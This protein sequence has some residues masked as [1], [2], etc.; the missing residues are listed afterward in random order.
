MTTSFGELLQESLTPTWTMAYDV[1]QRVSGIKERG[2]A[3]Y[4]QGD[5]AGAYVTFGEALKL[6][7]LDQ[8]AVQMVHTSAT[9]DRYVLNSVLSLL[10]SLFS[11]LAITTYKLGYWEVVLHYAS[12]AVVLIEKFSNAGERDKPLLWRARAFDQL[13]L[14]LHALSDAFS[15]R[16][17][18]PE[19]KELI[20][21]LQP[22]Y[23]ALTSGHRRALPLTASLRV[24]S[25]NAFADHGVQLAPGA[26]AAAGAAPSR[27]VF[28][29]DGRLHIFTLG[30]GGSGG[31]WQH[32]VVE[33]SKS[34]SWPEAGDDDEFNMVTH[35]TAPGGVLLLRHPPGRVPLELWSFDAN[36]AATRISRHKD[37]LEWPASRPGA[38]VAVHG[39]AVYMFGG[40]LADL[41]EI[42]LDTD[43]TC[44]ALYRFSGRSKRWMRMEL[45]SDIQGRQGGVMF[46]D[47][48]MMYV[49]YG[50]LRRTMPVWPGV[51]NEL[52]LERFP[53]EH[54]LSDLWC[55]ALPF[56][57][58]TNFPVTQS[59]LE[60][61]ST[62]PIFAAQP[63]GEM[64]LGVDQCNLAHSLSAADKQRLLSLRSRRAFTTHEEGTAHQVTFHHVSRGLALPDEASP[65]KASSFCA[66]QTNQF[67]FGLM[68][69]G[70]TTFEPARLNA[71]LD[72]DVVEHSDLYEITAL[73]MRRLLLPPD[74]AVP[75]T[76]GW[77]AAGI[78][79][80][81]TRTVRTL[82]V[83]SS[84]TA[85]TVDFAL[86]DNRTDCAHCKA[87][88][89]SA[90]FEQE[91]NARLL[92][93]I[94]NL[95]LNAAAAQTAASASS[96]KRK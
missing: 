28:V 66:V 75:P 89:S 34:K 74:C 22:R 16:K 36:G 90:T 24:L 39:T 92:R 11:N 64:T 29:F 58:S 44:D 96:A 50:S 71:P 59:R 8:S 80:A 81:A 15:I 70:E 19:A 86:C 27:S 13:Q 25:G 84:T 7:A 9:S 2:A 45:A 82:F 61:P 35:P 6:M 63:F 69:G 4:A 3:Q 41:P 54:C 49:G 30:G 68:L 51:L 53:I 46:A 47:G 18:L 10:F 62:T 87:C 78:Y 38:L 20:A 79:D 56:E 42:G 65:R 12:A 26:V 21:M 83:T 43:S 5:L 93:M 72:R 85:L 37:D 55:F 52:D 76:S 31:A 73:G 17:E 23:E 88:N 57:D 14:P 91:R 33:P 95:K 48:D 94:P 1:Y 40:I 67:G 60:N 32:R 77:C